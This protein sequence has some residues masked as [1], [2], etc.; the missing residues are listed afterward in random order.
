MARNGRKKGHLTV[1]FIFTQTIFSNSSEIEIDHRWPDE[2][3]KWQ[4]LRAYEAAH[5][6]YSLKNPPEAIS[7]YDM[8]DENYW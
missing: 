2:K 8:L 5:G 6:K 7:I 3:N 1:L 4:Q